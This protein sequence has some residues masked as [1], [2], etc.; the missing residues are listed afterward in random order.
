MA[1]KTQNTATQVEIP[2]AELPDD[3]LIRLAYVLQLMQISKATY[4]RGSRDGLF[5]RPIKY[6]RSSLFRVGSI[7]KMLSSISRLEGGRY[8]EEQPK[9]APRAVL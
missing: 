9:K 3:A 8:G 2:F 4:Y 7:R 6:G 1:A 5:P